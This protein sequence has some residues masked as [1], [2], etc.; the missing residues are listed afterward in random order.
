MNRY[1]H[2]GRA[3]NPSMKNISWLKDLEDCSI[4][5]LRGFGAIHSLVEMGVEGLAD[6]LNA[7]DAKARKVIEQLLMNQFEALAVTLV[8]RFFMSGQR[9]LETVDSRD[10][11]FYNSRC[12]ALLILGTLLFDALP[13]VVEVGLAAQQGLP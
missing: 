1:A 12:G 8:F 3:Q 4:R 2:H 9:M 13:V 6:G 11:R 5:H 7:D 10:E